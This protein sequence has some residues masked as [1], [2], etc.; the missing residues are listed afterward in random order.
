MQQ[1][2]IENSSME[3]DMDSLRSLSE[4]GIDVSFLESLEKEAQQREL[5]KQLQEQLDS[6]AQMLEHLQQVQTDR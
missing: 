2:E 5:T 4:L 3:I 1:V 6:N